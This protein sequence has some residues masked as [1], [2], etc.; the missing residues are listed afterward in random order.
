MK[1]HLLPVIRTR[2]C[3]M[4]IRRWDAGIEAVTVP[5]RLHGIPRLPLNQN[6][7]HNVHSQAEK[8]VENHREQQRWGDQPS[9][10]PERHQLRVG[11]IQV[12][13]KINSSC[14]FVRAGKCSNLHQ[15][16]SVTSWAHPSKQIDKLEYIVF[17]RERNNEWA[18]TQ[19]I[20]E[21]P[22]KA[23]RT[24]RRDFYFCLLNEQRPSNYKRGHDEMHTLLHCLWECTLTQTFCRTISQ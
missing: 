22:K 18:P 1:N 17:L 13:Y 19:V 2:W 10:R 9:C 24:I 14:I 7:A 15:K 16:N 12:H 6:E 3:L 4:E 23:D 21:S 11:T 8:N 5:V 20:W